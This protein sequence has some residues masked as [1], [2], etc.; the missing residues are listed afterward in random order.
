MQEKSPVRFM[1]HLMSPGFTQ[2]MTPQLVRAMG[3]VQLSE[4]QGLAVIGPGHA[5]IAVL[6]GQFS[7]GASGQLFDEQ[8]I[9][10]FAAGVQAISQALMVRADTER[11]Q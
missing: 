10:F 3:V 8:A 7:D 2:G 1:K 11:T 4:K 9:G 5:A 6:K